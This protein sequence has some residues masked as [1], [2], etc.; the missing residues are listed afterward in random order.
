M[1]K[2]RILLTGGT[3]LVG[4]ALSRRLETLG[5]DVITCGHT[6][7]FH[8]FN[9]ADQQSADML[10]TMTNPKMVIHL[11]AKVGGIYANM[12]GKAQFYL[13]NTL[14]NT[15]VINEVQKRE[16]P[17]VLAMGTGCAYPKR[18]EGDQLLEEDFLD[19]IPE[20]TNDAYAYSKRNLLVHLKACEQE[21]G[22]KYCYCIPA[23]LY[24]PYDNFHPSFSHVVPALIR[25]FVEAKRDGT[26]QVSVW[27]R[28]GMAGRDFLY[29][30]DLVDA[31]VLIIRNRFCGPINV[32]TGTAT[33]IDGLVGL[34]KQMTGYEGKIVYDSAY[35]EGQRTRI[36]NTDKVAGLGWIPGHSLK[37]GLEETINWYKQNLERMKNE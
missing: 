26:P 28:T 18:L 22:L 6:K 27:G 4:T 19:G 3:G 23:N 17:Y 24:G 33:T 20:A 37:Q 25:R 32:A 30:E 5:Y 8:K 10:F 15:N 21:Y 34:I 31:L 14:I 29:I 11:A 12:A 9:L 36:F 13:Q 1:M 2:D 35:P 7:G 16:V